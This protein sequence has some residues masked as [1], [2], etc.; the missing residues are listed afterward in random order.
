MRRTGTRVAALAALAS[1]LAAAGLTSSA[2]PQ[3]D[4]QTATTPARI[5]SKPAQTIAGFG[6]SG[7]WWPNDFRHFDPAMRELVADLLF[8]SKGI[9]LSAYRYVIGSGGVGV[10]SPQRVTGSFAVRPGAYDW[11]RSDPGIDVLKAAS[12]RGVTE[13]TG[14]A[15]SP[16]PMWTSNRKS[17][18]GLLRPGAEQAY[19]NYL[20][21]VVVHLRKVRGVTLTHVSPMNEPEHLFDT[22]YQEGAGVSI[23]QRVKLVRAL[24]RALRRR[25]LRTGVIAD[26]SSYVR[27]EFLPQARAWL[28]STNAS[29]YLSAVAFHMYD[30][31][32]NSA[33]RAA[34]GT[35]S[36][37]RKPLWMTEI[38][39]FNG[40]GYGEQY[41][42]T[43]DSALWLA[44]TVWQALTQA[45]ASMVSWWTALSPALGCPPATDPLCPVKV[46]KAGWNDGLL[47]YDPAFRENGNWLIYP[48]K[49]F[50]A[51]GNF[52]RF[53]RPGA[54]RHEVQRVPTG[55]RVAA[56]RSRQGWVIVAINDTFDARPLSLVFP[57]G[58][59]V[60]PT[61]AFVTTNEV[62]LAPAPVPGLDPAFGALVATLPPRSVT[63]YTFSPRS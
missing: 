46:N 44:D 13:L 10:R 34:A 15:M 45:N 6:A 9:A 21:N 31:P 1:I 3:R 35:A 40:R 20:A 47:Y 24:G 12:A 52:S 23:P 5:V 37:L 36:R 27:S 29:R 63:T 2:E 55:M 4:L 49:R 19:A 8:T 60:V 32:N 58:A 25:G 33:L 42:P 51:L 14:F 43:M 56:F 18:G 28:E 26:E 54:V 7:A 30:F 39:C 41:D 11:K 61:G 53:V 57:A 59:G 62:D 22:C 48:T 17:C 16:P 38:C 50:W